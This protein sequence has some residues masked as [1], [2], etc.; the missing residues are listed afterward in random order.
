ML[1]P[2]R[3]AREIT[4][5]VEHPNGTQDTVF[6]VK[7]SDTIYMVKGRLHGYWNIPQDEQRLLY[8]GSE[9]QDDRTIASYGLPDWAVVQMTLAMATSLGVGW[10]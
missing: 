5:I 9:M 7:K 6:D 10:V 1:K 2:Q 8:K 4:I 3:Q